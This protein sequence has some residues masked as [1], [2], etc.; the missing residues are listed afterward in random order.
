MELA[1]KCV[2]LLQ[3]VLNERNYKALNA[4]RNM[5]AAL[6]AFLAALRDIREY[7][8]KVCVLLWVSGGVSACGWLWVAVCAC[9]R[10]CVRRHV[11]VPVCVCVCVN[12]SVRALACT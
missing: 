5:R 6:E 2:A 8:D 12:S 1:E 7:I 9:V 4:E 10:V 3:H 11:F